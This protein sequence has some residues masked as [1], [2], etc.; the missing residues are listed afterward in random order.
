MEVD[1]LRVAVG[2]HLS[3]CRLVVQVSFRFE[4]FWFLF[5]N[6]RISRDGCLLKSTMG[7][8]IVLQFYVLLISQRLLFRNYA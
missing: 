3:K 2:R 4:V 1:S 5:G 8:I 7:E 6:K